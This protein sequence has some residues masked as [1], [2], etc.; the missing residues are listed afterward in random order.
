M[1]SFKYTVPM[2]TFLFAREKS[3]HKKTNLHGNKVQN[4]KFSWKQCSKFKLWHVL[5]QNSIQLNLH[6]KLLSNGVI[7]SPPPPLESGIR[8][9][10]VLES[11]VR[12]KLQLGKLFCEKNSKFCVCNGILH[13]LRTVYHA[14]AYGIRCKKDP[15]PTY[16][17]GGYSL[18]NE[19]SLWKHKLCPI[20]RS[21]L[22][23]WYMQCIET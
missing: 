3:T 21:E 18:S 5:E 8:F 1:Q 22:S 10:F 19:Y 11:S 23:L 2:G 9:K 7:I 13:V 6:I 14:F 17:N 16:E 15:N 4:A 12:F 20:V